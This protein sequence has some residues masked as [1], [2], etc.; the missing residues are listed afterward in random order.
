VKPV[1]PIETVDLFPELDTFL[2]ALPYTYREVG[3][4]EGTTI[5]FHIEGNAGG[6]WSL[7][8]QDGA[9]ESYAGRPPQA[10][11]EV[12]LDQD[13]AWR[14]FTKGVRPEDARLKFSIEG[15]QGLGMRIL[16]MV[17]IMA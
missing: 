10:A 12:S 7:V 15:D 17:S 2:R 3:G 4:A 11:S 5:C 16:K 9:W 6:D 14:L 13:L 1:E 8:R